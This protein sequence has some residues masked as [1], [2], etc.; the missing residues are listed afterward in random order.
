MSVLFI[1]LLCFL[2]F[3]LIRL[4]IKPIGWA[5]KLLFHALIGF[6]ALF[7]F[8][9]FGSIIGLSLELSWINAL[10]TGVLGLP[11]V[12]LLLLLRYLGIY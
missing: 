6:V 2:A 3:L 9:F 4:L 11:G 8:N 12:I 7:L 1:L 10:I 5:I